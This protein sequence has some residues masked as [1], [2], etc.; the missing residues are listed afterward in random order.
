MRILSA[1][2]APKLAGAARARAAWSARTERRQAARV[3]EAIYLGQM[4]R[5]HLALE[6]SGTAMVAAM[7]F[8]GRVYQAGEPVAVSWDTADIW[9]VG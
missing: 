1:S 3:V 4:V 2:T 8:V 7:P 9:P 5:Y 6:G